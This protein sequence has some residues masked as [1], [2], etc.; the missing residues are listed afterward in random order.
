M[1][2]LP[3]F[4]L[5]LLFLA[6]PGFALTYEP[7]A[8]APTRT[9]E[10]YI[11]NYVD[12]P[13][14]ALDWKTLGATREIDI[15]TKTPDGL[16]LEYYK[17]GFTPEVKALDGKKVLIKG[18]MFPLD[19]TDRQRLFL[20]GP[21]PVNCPFQYHV[22]PSLVIEVHADAAPVKFSYDPVTLEGTLRLVPEDPENSTFYR[23]E[24]A[25]RVT[26]K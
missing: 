20:F 26:V 5:A 21:F 16:D 17:P 12:I 3:F 8:D 1:R 23:L 6:R 11:K 10:D 14:G 15:R 4:L 9:L 2:R 24:D 13:K 22:G 7:G 19:E 25:K 18:F